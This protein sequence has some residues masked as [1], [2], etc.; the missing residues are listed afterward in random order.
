M[1]AYLWN[2]AVNFSMVLMGILVTVPHWAN[3]LVLFSAR[4]HYKNIIDIDIDINDYMTGSIAV[5]Q[6]PV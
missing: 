2:I 4:V 6:P 1:I 3:T 5:Y